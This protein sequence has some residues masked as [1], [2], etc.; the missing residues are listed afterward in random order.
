MFFVFKFTL[1]RKEQISFWGVL[2]ISIFIIRVLVRRNLI[3]QFSILTSNRHAILN[4]TLQ[5]TRRVHN[6]SCQQERTMIQKV[7]N[8]KRCTH[9]N[10]LSSI[11][12]AVKVPPKKIWNLIRNKVLNKLAQFSELIQRLFI[13]NWLHHKM[14]IS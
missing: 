4:F 6:L 14:L 12:E 9:N 13:A 8:L 7:Q 11:V 3:W 5:V 10:K 2:I 1:P